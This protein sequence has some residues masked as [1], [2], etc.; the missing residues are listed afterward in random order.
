MP[1]DA[2]SSQQDA[3]KTNAPDIPTAI[4]QKNANVS[5]LQSKMWWI[6][7][8]CFAVA[9]GLAWNSLPESGTEIMIRFPEG[10][11]LQEGDEVRYR[12]ISVGEVTEVALDKDLSG[13]EVSV[14]LNPAGGQ[15]NHE[16]ARFWIVRPQ[17]SLTRI[18][19]LET[20]VGHKYIGASP[21]DFSGATKFE[22]DGL[23][24]APADELTSGGLHLV[25][26]SNNSNGLNPG[27][28]V[29]W[30][31][32]DVGR[33]LSVNLSP[34]ARHVLTSIHV[35]RQ[36]RK[37][38]RSSSRF[39]IT[40]GI[41]IDLSFTK[42]VKL[43]AQSL[44]TI[45]RGGVSFMTPAAADVREVSDGH[46]FSL[47]DL[48]NEEWLDAVEGLPL[49]E[50]PLPKTVTVRYARPK[51][52]INLARKRELSFSGV[53]TEG[54]AGTELLIPW[55]SKL[56]EAVQRELTI[57]FGGKTMTATIDADILDGASSDGFARIPIDTTAGLP[58]NPKQAFRS[59]DAPEDCFLVRTVGSN[60]DSV[61]L[62]H[63]VYS[64]QLQATD[65]A[66][67]TKLWTLASF[68]EDLSDWLGAPAISSKDG[69]IIGL[70][71]QTDT[72]LAVVLIN[73]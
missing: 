30:R 49:I 51:S 70:L 2:S 62:I 4:V 41:D 42:G 55:T 32:V 33:I 18:A 7:L 17:I 60:K 15:L 40:S 46:V 27:A 12:G 50:F 3:S 61:G 36:F 9:V 69:K 45:A 35:D 10:H 66:A 43:N 47:S 19:G 68:E 39:W 21:G 67:S 64:E 22:F 25:L 72:G 37:L 20:A 14:V 52:L 38:V 34:D 31:G 71:T 5:L 53:L 28:P 44:A 6:T 57:E 73:N 13:V 48:P 24:T 16:G 58:V 65:N 11:G 54:S 8:I 56:K 26:R 1:Q 63:S 59:A 29:T 23:A